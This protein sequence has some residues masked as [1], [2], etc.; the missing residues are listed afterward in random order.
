M[1]FSS[2]EAL[3]EAIKNDINQT[4]TLLSEPEMQVWKTH[5]F[6]QLDMHL[7]ENNNDRNFSIKSLSNGNGKS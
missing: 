4:E 6:F 7:N 5:E 3:I 1:N 2:L